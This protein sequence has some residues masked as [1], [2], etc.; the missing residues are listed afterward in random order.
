MDCVPVPGYAEHAVATGLDNKL[1]SAFFSCRRWDDIFNAAVATK[2]AGN[3]CRPGE[4]ANILGVAGTLALKGDSVD[5]IDHGF[6]SWI[7]FD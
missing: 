7:E 5:R 1:M 4:G 2:T 3:T 6:T